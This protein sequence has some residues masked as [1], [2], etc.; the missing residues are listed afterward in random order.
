MDTIAGHHERAIP[1]AFHEAPGDDAGTVVLLPGGG[2]TPAHPLLHFSRAAFNSV[3]FSVFELWWGQTFSGWHEESEQQQ[4]RWLGADALAAVDAAAA[5]GRLAGFVVKSL[6]T[7]GLAA[8]AEQRRE[9]A[10]LPTVWL[11]PILGRADVVNQLAAW[12][13]PSVA[14]I[15]EQDVVPTGVDPEHLGEHVDSMCVPGTNHALERE[16]PVGSVQVLQ[17]IVVH[18]RNFA[19]GLRAESG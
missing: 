11:T 10:D 18:I 3:G 14:V 2:Y 13:A 9:L 7:M 15:A 1:F 17:S 6:G 12:R 16:D 19:L 8:A 5:R 4:A